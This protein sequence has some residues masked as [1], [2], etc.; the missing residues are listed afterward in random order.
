MYE[1]ISLEDACQILLQQTKPLDSELISPLQ[2]TGR[3]LAADI[4]A[5]HDLPS[6]RQAAMDGFALAETT[7]DRFLIKKHL[8]AGEVPSFTLK[9]G[10][11][12]GVVTGGH[13]PQSTAVVV[14]DEDVCV[15]DGYLSIK[16]INPKV[17]NIRE[18][19]EDF[20]AGTVIA[21]TGTK[22]T[23]GLISILTAYGFRE[24]SAVRVPRVAILSLGKEIIPCDQGIKPGQVR[25][26]NGPLLASLVTTHGGSPI[27]VVAPGSSAVKELDAQL[28]KADLVVTIGGTAAGSNDQAKDLL[29]QIGAQPLFLGYQVKPGS[30]S[31]AGIRD[32]KL[33]VMLSGNPVA[34]FVGYHLLV[35]PVLHALQGL[36]PKLLHI[37]AMAT[38]GF[39]KKGGPRRFLLGY[40]LFGP[41]GWRVAVLSGQKSSMRRS[42]ADCNC[43]ID[44]AAGHPPVKPGEQVFIILIQNII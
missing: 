9:G 3:I 31:C 24:I 10:E 42:L 32:G 35:Y 6:Y 40:T 20:L 7:G 27:A 21:R 19:G 38:S 11:A 41:E 44:L 30:H 34:C 16:R 33:V 29:E 39:P 15:E 14:R 5:P 43:L 8:A 18:Q 37:P 12:A 13:I 25:D 36:K 2:G 26:S 28:K 23:P 1:N 4:I 17:N 22:I